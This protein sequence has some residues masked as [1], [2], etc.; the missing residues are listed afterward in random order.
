LIPT[1]RRRAQ[2][3]GTRQV[4]DRAVFT[5]IVYVLTSD[6]AWWHPPPD[7]ACPR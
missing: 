5:P 2:G 4:D 6:F 7:S 1:Q 3:G